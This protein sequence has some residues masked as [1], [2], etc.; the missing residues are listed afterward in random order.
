MRVLSSWREHQH[1]R[2]LKVNRILLISITI[3]LTITSTRVLT[4]TCN[5]WF[6]WF[7][8]Y[9]FVYAPLFCTLT[10]AGPVRPRPLLLPASEDAALPTELRVR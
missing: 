7:L 6:T 3:L 1:T 4:Y 5:Y 10:T 8:L 2:A 9:T